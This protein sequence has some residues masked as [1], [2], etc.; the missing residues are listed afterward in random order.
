MNGNLGREKIPEKK[1]QNYAWEESPREKSG[2]LLD[3]IAERIAYERI[4]VRLYDTILL[5]HLEAPHREGLPPFELLQQFHR[6]EVEHF[7][8]LCDIMRKLGGDPNA[9]SPSASVESVAGHGWIDVV[10]NPET[11]FEQCLHIIHLAELGDNDSWELL[12]DL[13]EASDL[14][15][16]ARIFRN[17]LA[18][19]EGHLLNVRNWIRAHNLPENSH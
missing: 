3:K 10:T 5:K 17:C 2:H 13:A 7:R 14:K 6:E 8:K 15:E 4:V 11:S 18:E 1:R 16:E 12:T 19:E 9:V